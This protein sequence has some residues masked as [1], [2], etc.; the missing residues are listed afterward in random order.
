MK[1]LKRFSEAVITPEKMGES[2]EI[3]SYEKLVKYGEENGFDVVSYDEFYNSL[4][5]ED[6][7]TAPPKGFPFFALFH[8]INKRPMFVLHDQQMIKRIPNFIEI[9]KDII[10][11]ERIH[12]GQVSKSKIPYKLP[13]PNQRK[14]YLSDK[15][16]IMAFSWTIANGLSK[17][18]KTVE[19]AV[20]ELDKKGFGRE[21]HQ[22]MWNDIKNSCDEKILKRY[23]KYI[24]MYL[25]KMLN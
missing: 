8:P 3:D 6:K 7:K 24:Y 15:M 16:E 19:D 5:E 13:D 2:G 20:K 23:R 4:G 18:C 14:E 17:T 1:Y 9:V 12:S 25:N 22:Q 10:G 21:Q 11:H